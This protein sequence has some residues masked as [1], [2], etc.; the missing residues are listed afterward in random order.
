[1]CS[2]AWNLGGAGGGEEP[3]SD[4]ACFLSSPSIPPFLSCPLR[5]FPKSCHRPALGQVLGIPGTRPAMCF[6]FLPP[7]LLLSPLHQALITQASSLGQT[8]LPPSC[9]PHPLFSAQPLP[10]SP[11]YPM[12]ASRSP[13]P[14]RRAL[15]WLCPSWPL[16]S[17]SFCPLQNLLDAFR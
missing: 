6:L 8:L 15:V 16:P 2:W 17:G 7:C 9:L 1:M 3:G 11:P 13:A 14:H 5:S 12:P 10:S 4:A